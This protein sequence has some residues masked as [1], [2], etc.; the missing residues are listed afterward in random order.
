MFGLADTEVPAAAR[1]LGTAHTTCI[2]AGSAGPSFELGPTGQPAGTDC[3]LP[4]LK[5]LLGAAGLL[6]VK[7]PITEHTRAALGPPAVQVSPRDLYFICST[8]ACFR[9]AVYAGSGSSVLCLDRHQHESGEL[10]LHLPLF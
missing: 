3:I 1:L 10:A 5:W 6:P 7:L 2:L 4:K 9:Q 8:T